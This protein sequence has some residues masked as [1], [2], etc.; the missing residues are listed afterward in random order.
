MDIRI[1]TLII[2]ALNVLCSF[3]GFKDRSFFETYKF[4]VGGIKRGEKL[5]MLV[6]GF[7]HVDLQ[8]LLFNM[9]TLYFF[10]DQVIYKVGSFYFFLIYFGSLIFGNL[11]SYYFHKNESYYSAVGASGAVTGI[12]YAA[13]L[14]FP[15]MELYLY[16]IPIPIPSYI[17]GVGYMMYS[18]Y[19]M[20]SRVG[21]IGHDAHF[22]G[23]IG[24]YVLTLLIAPQVLETH[25]WMVILLAVPII[26]LFVM[27]QN[28]KI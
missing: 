19:G 7:L 23:A 4:N 28:N 26:I 20:K 11:L 24:G 22:G 6:S 14:L 21:N 8:H 12:L 2:I 1:Y 3:K 15:G 13:I 27:H 10:A 16:F 17:V 5:R 18:I 25:L 9:I